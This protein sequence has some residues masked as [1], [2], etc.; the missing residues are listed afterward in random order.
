MDMMIMHALMIMIITTAMMMTAQ[1]L[2]P[3]ILTMGTD[4]ILNQ[5]MITMNTEMVIV[6]T[7]MKMMMHMVMRVI[8]GLAMVAVGMATAMAILIP[9]DVF[10]NGSH[11]QAVFSELYD[12]SD[13][14]NLWQWPR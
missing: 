2:K 9:M 11:S 7:S 12:S 10:R 5:G 6:S 1:R 4:T 13:A 8:R 14:R 3:A